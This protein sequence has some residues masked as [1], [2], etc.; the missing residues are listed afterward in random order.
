VAK[1]ADTFVVK[2]QYVIKIWR[3]V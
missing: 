2:V 3:L 1:T